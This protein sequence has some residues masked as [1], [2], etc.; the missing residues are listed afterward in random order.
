MNS[1]TGKKLLILGGM[2]QHRKLVK[3]AKELGIETWVTDYL[4]LEE[5]P[6]KQ[7]ADHAEMINITE[8]DRLVKLCR[9]EHI[10]GIIAPYLDV[11]QKPYQQI[12]ERMN[13]PCFGTARQ[14][15]IL[16]D[17]QQFKAF[18]ETHGA[19]IIPGYSEEDL[20]KRNIEYPILVKPSDS[21]GSRGQTICRNKEEAENAIRFAQKESTSGQAVIEK[22]MENKQDLQLVYL[23]INGEPLLY[24]VED[25]YTGSPDEGL[26]KIATA[27]ISPSK[28]E[29]KYR[30]QIDAKVSGMIRSIGLRN[31][32][33]FIQ[34][35]MDGDVVRLYDPGIRMPGDDY[36]D[37]HKALTGIDIPELLIHFALTGEMPEFAAGQIKNKRLKGYAVMILPC[38]RPGKIAK[39]EGLE[40]IDTHPNIVTWSTAHFV[41]DAIRDDVKLRQRYGE[42][43]ITASDKEQLR[44]VIQWLY[45]T[46]HVYDET[47]EEMITGR[48]DTKLLDDYE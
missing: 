22:Y 23:V 48:F 31:S 8:I 15:E 36:D 3:K 20:E 26:D 9:D 46:L 42:F 27:C 6:A 38:L 2:Y 39:I 5:A 25:R 17:K 16:T 19:D 7:M 1:F 11:T 40:L 45:E 43:V 10:D 14:H 47:G 32:P 24:K 33:V 37:A 13:W 28:Y 44:T 21:R 4:P 29:K 18:C 30:D 41:G 12:C 35:F 34:A